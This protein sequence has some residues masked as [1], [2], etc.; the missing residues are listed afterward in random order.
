MSDSRNWSGWQP[1]AAVNTQI[2]KEN[3]IDSNWKYRQFIQHHGSQ[4]RQY[5]NSS[6]GEHIYTNTTPSD[7]VPYR[8]T[9][10]FDTSKPGFGYS[11]S[12]L[13]SPYLSREQ[14]NARMVAPIIVLPSGKNN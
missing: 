3:N 14:L 11:N 6:E 4:I 13:K 12:D 2:R 8:F 9:S 10:V 7:N 1:D 5:N